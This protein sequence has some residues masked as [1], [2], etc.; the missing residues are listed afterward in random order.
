MKVISYIQR[1]SFFV[2]PSRNNWEITERMWNPCT[3]GI[4][5]YSEN[6]VW[7][8]KLENGVLQVRS[9]KFNLQKRNE[10]YLIKLECNDKAPTRLSFQIHK[11]YQWNVQT[12]RTIWNFSSLKGFFC[13][14]CFGD[15]PRNAL[16][17]NYH[18]YLM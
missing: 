17:L 3:I 5:L 1:C 7:K 14:F 12:K 9:G 16:N 18:P 11:N 2:S 10:Q 6:F 8:F 4:I 15:Y 13:L